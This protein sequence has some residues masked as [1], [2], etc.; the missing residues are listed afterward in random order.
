ML[1]ADNTHVRFTNPADSGEHAANEKLLFHY[2]QGSEELGSPFLYE[3]AFLSPKSNL[4]PAALLGKTVGVELDLPDSPL[5][6][7]GGH[8][9]F[10]GYVT[11]LARQGRHGKY[12]AYSA[13]VRPWLSLLGRTSNCRIFQNKTVPDIIKEVFSEYTISDVKDALASSYA[14]QDYVVQYRETDLDFVTRLMAQEGIYYFFMHEPGRHVLVLADSSGAHAEVK[15]YGKVPFYSASESGSSIVEH[16]DSWNAE[17]QIRSG[18]MV[19]KDFNFMTPKQNLLAKRSA[20]NEHDNA[21]FRIYDY[22]GKYLNLSQGETYAR[23]RLEEVNT[24]QDQRIGGG[25]VRGIA[26]GCLFNLIPQW[27]YPGF[28]SVQGALNSV[29]DTGDGDRLADDEFR[30][31]LVTAANFDIQGPNYESKGADSGEEV[32]RC[33]LVAID[34]HHDFRMPRE[35]S[36]PVVHGPHTATVVGDKDEDITTDLYGRVKVKFHWDRRGETIENGDGSA[37]TQQEPKDKDKNGNDPNSSCWVRVA[38][39]WA[40]AKFGAINIP[41]IGDE[42]IVDFLEG[43]PDRPIITGRVY[44]ADNMP[45]YT[46]PDNKT[47]TGIKTRS[48]KGGNPDNFNEIRFEDKK[49]KEELHIQAERDMSTHVKRNQS[50]S[51]DGDQTITVIG[52]Q[53]VTIQGKG[54][55]PVHSTTSVTGKHTFDASDTIKIQAPT[56]ITLECGGSSIV[57]VPGTITFTAGGGA[58]IVLD[59]NVLAAANAK[60]K[61]LLDANVLAQS[62]GG[63]KV[64]LDAN[65]LAEANGK[66]KVVLDANVLA[67]SS[68]N[69]KVVLDGDAT[70]EGTGTATVK[71][72]SEATLTA[73]GAVKTS[74]A[75]VEATGTKIDITGSAAVNVTG[76]MVKIN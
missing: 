70:M 32:F 13:R 53:S 62:D 19:L 51:V 72:T 15:G 34:S 55:S 46:L 57:M 6:P 45:P 69:S 22:P 42:V 52:N 67:Q 30:E 37:G 9:Y 38:Q 8:R 20:P 21:G 25:N 56:S 4:D 40:G 1:T 58:S 73:T 26:A 24:N 71:G 14:P 54:K 49:G 35:V 18:T 76:A 39:M 47:Q 60:A 17:Q 64:V 10:H 66:A 23:L 12:Y 75:G 2:M 28:L 41:R 68:G 11:H 63:A 29:T 33:T 36:K 31:Y 61:V 16:I 43:D 65:V 44:N 74:P 7:I 59:A 48:S 3:V 27:Q 5:Q 50:T